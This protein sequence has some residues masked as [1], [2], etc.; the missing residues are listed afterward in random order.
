[1]EDRRERIQQLIAIRDEANAELERIADQVAA[2]L[3][4]VKGGGGEVEKPKRKWT[5]R[6]NGETPA[7][8]A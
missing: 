8:E 3:N 2:E 7:P 1:M 4:A 5:R 6:T